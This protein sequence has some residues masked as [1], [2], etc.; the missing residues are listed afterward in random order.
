MECLDANDVQNLMAGALDLGA[1]ATVLGHL[2][3]CEDCR[4]VLSITASDVSRQS[5]APFHAGLD[6]TLAPEGLEATALP[7]IGLQAT[8]AASVVPNDLL[9]TPVMRAS[10]AKPVTQG[11][12]L[13]RFTLVDRLGAGAMGVVWCAE[14]PKLGRN[15]AVKVLRRADAGLTERLVREAQSMAQVNH[16]NVV[17]VYEVGEAE[18]GTMF[19]AMEL[20]TGQSL[21]GWQTKTK[22]TVPA[23]VAAYIAAGRGLAAAHAAGI[24]HRDFKPDNVLVG[25]DGRIRVTDF[26]LAAAKPGEGGPP[27]PAHI[28]DV[29]L[30]TSGSVL[31]TP[32]Y[33]APEQF[34]SGNVDSRTDQF[35][36][37]VALYEAL[38]G[39][40]PFDGKTFIELGDNVKS[41]RILPAPETARVSEALREILLRGLSVKPGDRFATM[42]DL[43]TEL[44][45]DRARPWRRTATASVAVAA[46]LVLG[47]ASDWVVRDRLG[48]EIKQS[49]ALTGKQ[50]D[51]AVTQ[52]RDQFDN[53][54]EIVYREPALREVAA[55]HDQ[56]DFGLGS[57]EDDKAELERLHNTLVS[58]DLVRLGT[59]TLVVGDYKGRLLFTTA[60]PPTWGTDLKML[61]FVKRALDA[62]KGDS[63]T[64]L[65]YSDP[66]LVATGM[67]GSHPSEGLVVIFARTLALGDRSSDA[68]EARAV[69]LQIQDG[70]QLVDNVEL[71]ETMLTLVGPSG[72]AIGNARMSPSLTRAA[73]AATTVTEV[74]DG[75]HTYQ[76]QV[77]SVIGL[78]GQGVIAHVV[79]A[80]PLDGVLSLFPGARL[81]FALMALGALA[82]GVFAFLRAREI[83]HGRSVNNEL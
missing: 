73:L 19:I 71:D 60:D 44:G 32:A 33:M 62:G 63:V 81:V 48:A 76:V 69:Y 46:V 65:P 55:Y 20:V 18:D 10:T 57:P 16:P 24:V 36:F 66:A 15:V 70:K 8:Q 42:N 30:T 79:M 17:T 83:T 4:E 29:N 28:S 45:R 5:L 68:N 21:R 35:N 11:K 39:V 51:R 47:L 23:L 74:D 78:D 40:R 56:N 27:S 80:R 53:V 67:L 82:L 26:G 58:A 50:L 31:G 3:T 64:V 59:S 6:A 9:A 72:D 77:R 61:P 2:D 37:C 25:D 43:I 12:R 52:L 7:D 41:G 54:S 49:F 75:G 38:Y 34:T 22:R 1:R 14:D 13:G